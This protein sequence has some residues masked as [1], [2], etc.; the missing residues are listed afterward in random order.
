M[1]ILL[2]I[3]G[4]FTIFTVGNTGKFK[5]PRLKNRIRLGKEVTPI[6][7]VVKS[8]AIFRWIFGG[9]S[10]HAVAALPIIE[11]LQPCPGAEVVVFY[12]E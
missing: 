7:R 3:F 9:C 12:D 2:T 4:P 6:I 11:I 10:A 8:C 1:T 5:S